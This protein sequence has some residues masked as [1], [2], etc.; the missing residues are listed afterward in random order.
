[1]KTTNEITSNPIYTHLDLT[2]LESIGKIIREENPYSVGEFYEFASYV[3]RFYNSKDGLYPFNCHN[4]DIIE[5]CQTVMIH[6]PSFEG[7]SFDRENV[8]LMLESFG[9]QEQEK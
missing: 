4:D 6:K 2:L 9:Y 5:L 1:M 7:D 8:R 3:L